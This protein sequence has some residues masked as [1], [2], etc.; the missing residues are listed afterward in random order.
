MTIDG[1]NAVPDK[2]IQTDVGILD[3][4][5]AFNSIPCEPL[6]GKLDYYG[7]RNPTNTWIR[8]FLIKLSMSAIVGGESSEL[9]PILSGVPQEMGLGPMLYLFY[10]NDM[11]T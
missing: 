6:W 1:L 10:I 5:R 11:P 2:K 9:T 8:A 4:S 3:F 7:I